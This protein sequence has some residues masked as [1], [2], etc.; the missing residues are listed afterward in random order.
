MDGITTAHAHHWHEPL[1]APDARGGTNYS[2]G[3]TVHGAAAEFVHTCMC[4]RLQ[5]HTSTNDENK[6]L[7][8]W[9]C[10]HF[11]VS[12]RRLVVRVHFQTA[13]FAHFSSRLLLPSLSSSIMAAPAVL[14]K[15]DK[16]HLSVAITGH[17][18]SGQGTR[19]GAGRGAL[20]SAHSAREVR[21]RRTGK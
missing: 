8:I 5:P 11:A 2:E 13:R 19:S 17:V 3:A 6:N 21:T 1:R 10:L 9:C 18:D 20:G 7:C 16:K 12:T 4:M 14:D 15:A